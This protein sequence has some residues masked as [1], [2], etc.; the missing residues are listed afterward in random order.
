MGWG[1]GAVDFMVDWSSVRSL[2]AHGFLPHGPLNKCRH[3][4]CSNLVPVSAHWQK[5]CPECLEADFRNHDVVQIH[6]ACMN[7]VRKVRIVLSKLLLGKEL[8][9][10]ILKFIVNDLGELHPSP[11]WQ[12]R[13]MLAGHI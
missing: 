2:Q 12:Y 6:R 8:I 7:R 4:P 13:L 10:R 3:A 9:E 11:K 1:P 5:E